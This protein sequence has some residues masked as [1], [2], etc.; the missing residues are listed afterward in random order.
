LA[1]THPETLP[2]LQLV[3]GKEIGLIS[4]SRIPFFPFIFDI[5]Q[6]ALAFAVQLYR[7][8]DGC[9]WRDGADCNTGNASQVLC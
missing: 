8:S 1:W 7:C 4:S 6:N 9:P 5:E 2:R 3:K